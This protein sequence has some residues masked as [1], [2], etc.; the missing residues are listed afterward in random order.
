MLCD[1][2]FRGRC[3]RA[4]TIGLCMTPGTTGAPPT[5]VATSRRRA[6][7]SSCTHV[8]YD[9]HTYLASAHTLTQALS[10]GRSQAC[11]NKPH[12]SIEGP[13][14]TCHVVEVLLRAFSGLL[15]GSGCGRACV[16]L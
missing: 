11:T 4:C 7:T 1:F 3:G 6:L 13:L 15:G 9:V 2:H 14:H 10:R 8:G 5:H 12:D 16:G